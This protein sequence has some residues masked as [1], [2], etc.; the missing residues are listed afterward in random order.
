[1]SIS[2]SSWFSRSHKA[3]GKE[4]PQCCFSRKIVASSYTR[5]VEE[6]REEG[7]KPH[8]GVF[9]SLQAVAPFRVGTNGSGA[10][11]FLPVSLLHLLFK[12]CL[13]SFLAHPFPPSH[14]LLLHCGFIFSSLLLYPIFSL[15][16]FL[17]FLHLSK[18]LQSFHSF[19]P[20]CQSQLCFSSH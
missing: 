4:E 14:P 5:F 9:G 6:G 12:A 1:M 7:K 20:L 18:I 3:N 19:L 15:F 2:K 13:A 17:F 10:S 8:Q 16:S 11:I